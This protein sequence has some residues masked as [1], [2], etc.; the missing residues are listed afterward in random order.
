[1]EVE[2]AGEHTVFTIE[3]LERFADADGFSRYDIRTGERRSVVR[4]NVIKEPQIVTPQSAEAH[5]EA[6]EYPE[7]L[8]AYDEHGVFTADELKEIT[9][10]ILQYNRESKVGFAQ[11]LLDF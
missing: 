6:V 8:P 4:I 7:K 5:L 1:M 9:A 10:A 3:Q 11:F 2:I